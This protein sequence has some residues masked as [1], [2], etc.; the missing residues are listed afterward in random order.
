ML[1]VTLDLHSRLKLRVEE[2]MGF[3][4]K[5]PLVFTRCFRTVEEKV[6]NTEPLSKL[7]GRCYARKQR[8][9]VRA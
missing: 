9:G 6:W 8:S 7:L 4:G 1:F 5:D 2:I 3:C